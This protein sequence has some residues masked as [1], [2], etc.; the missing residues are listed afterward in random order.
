MLFHNFILLK[1]NIWSGVEKKKEGPCRKKHGVQ[2]H[3]NTVVAL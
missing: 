2:K 3:L 1:K